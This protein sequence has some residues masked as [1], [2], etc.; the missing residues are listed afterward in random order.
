MTVR[1]LADT[2]A[3][4]SDPSTS[5]AGAEAATFSMTAL[6]H[7]VLELINERPRSVGSELNGRYT[8][9]ALLRGYPR[10]HWD[11]PRKRAGDLHRAGLV[12]VVG[13]RTVETNRPESE[14]E[15]T[16]EGRAYLEVVS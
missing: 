5:K 16:E 6:R 4:E 14:Y 3:R 1:T 8:D 10:T 13:I 11:S 15:I 2:L 7:A 12:R 9:V